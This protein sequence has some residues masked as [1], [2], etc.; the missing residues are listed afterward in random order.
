MK[1]ER[2]AV[3]FWKRREMGLLCCGLKIA[4]NWE[5]IGCLGFS[6]GE[7][8]GFGWLGEEDGVKR[9]GG[10]EKEFQSGEKEGEVCS[11]FKRK[12]KTGWGAAVWKVIGLGLGLG[13]GFFCVFPQYTKL[14]PHV[15]VVE[16][17]IYR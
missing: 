1:I 3:R 4:R 5:K 9:C 8:T 7:G 14:L 2:G 11:G 13:F 10:S 12:I 17:S 16:T 6:Q 15:C